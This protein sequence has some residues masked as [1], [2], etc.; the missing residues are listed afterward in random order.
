MT[1]STVGWEPRTDPKIIEKIDEFTRDRFSFVAPFC[2]E[3][4]SG[5][6][7]PTL[8]ANASKARAAEEEDGTTFAGWEAKLE[9]GVLAVSKQ[10]RSEHRSEA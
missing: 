7:R 2:I 10:N 5:R 6:R 4:S 1:G 3:A 9:P 8:C